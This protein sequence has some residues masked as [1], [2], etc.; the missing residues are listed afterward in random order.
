MRESRLDTLVLYA[1]YI[2]RLSYFD[3]WLDALAAAPG[4]ATT[5]LNICDRNTHAAIAAR[6]REVDLTILLHSTNGDTTVYLEPILPLLQARRGLALSFVGNE[7]NLPGSPIAAKRLAFTRFEPDFIATQLPLEAGQYLWG[8]LVRKQVLAVPHALN[9]AAFRPEVPQERRQLDIGVRA[10]QYLPHLGDEERNRLHEFFLR[11]RFEPPLKVEVSSAR[12]DRQGWAA[13]LND[14]RGTVSTEAGSWYLER[15]D[16][17]VEAIREWTAQTYGSGRLVI[18]NDSPLR[19]LGHKLPWGLRA[20]LRRVLS[21]GLVRHEST[22]TEAIP[23][24]AVWER[25][26]RDYP[27]P[28]FYGKCISS[29]HFDAVGTKTCQIMFPGRFNDILAADQHYIALKP[30]FTNLDEAI[31]RFRDPAAR[32][33][34]VD[35]AREHVMA[36]HTYAHRV[37]ALHAAITA[38]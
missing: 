5:A 15:D 10:V 14:T 37:A 18:A 32:T 8:D 11:H 23:F 21:R 31:G 16:R 27:K 3:D 29:R 7:V 13:Y 28:A 2:T 38:A 9:P 24:Q 1:D 25:F 34:I 19:K 26:F 12:L 33:A 20:L 6:L 30:D 4:F 36:A 17:T 35:R 22:I